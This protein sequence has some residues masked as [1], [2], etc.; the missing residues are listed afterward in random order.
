MPRWRPL[1]LAGLLL[2]VA[3]A[4]GAAGDRYYPARAAVRFS[5]RGGCTAAIV[6][7]IRNARR[8][9]RLQAYSFTSAPIAAALRDAAKRGVRVTALLDRSNQSRRYSGATFLVNAGIPT[10]IDARHSIAH[11]KILLIDRA[12]LITGSFN[13]TRAAESAN[14]ENL[15]IIKSAP[16]LL[17]AY[18]A[19]FDRHL[20]HAAR[21]QALA[22]GR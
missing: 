8:E 14:A 1:Q 15:L 19:N 10:W 4:D 20:K 21:Y 22:P 3:L 5:P 9:V 2:A 18:E 16:G 7:E 11:N 6:R 12:T 13:F 17:R